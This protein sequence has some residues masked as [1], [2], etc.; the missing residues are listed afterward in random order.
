M[1]ALAV[2]VSACAIPPTCLSRVIL[3]RVGL[4]A[5]FLLEWEAISAL[6][7]NTYEPTMAR[8]PSAIN[9]ANFK[10]TYSMT[11]MAAFHRSHYSPN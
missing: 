1:M 10:S 4:L 7:I 8:E 11:L 9:T 6:P 3:L 5:D 2:G